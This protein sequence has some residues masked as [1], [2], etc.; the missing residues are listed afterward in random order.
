MPDVALVPTIDCPGCDGQITAEMWQPQ[1][2]DKADRR[3][4]NCPCGATFVWRRGHEVV[5]SFLPGDQP[6]RERMRGAVDEPPD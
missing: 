5:R 6:R 4:A 2:P 3:Y 1:F